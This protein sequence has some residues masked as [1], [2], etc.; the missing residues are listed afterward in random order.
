ML[1]QIEGP[2]LGGGNQT[3]DDFDVWQD[4]NP[5]P[6]SFLQV[7]LL[8]YISFTLLPS[9]RFHGP[10]SFLLHLLW[11]IHSLSGLV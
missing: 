6:S 2:V 5:L 10:A 9:A 4:P 1:G 3:K 7:Q 11:T 8:L